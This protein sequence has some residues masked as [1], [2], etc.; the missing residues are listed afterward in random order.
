MLF[1][2]KTND[3]HRI[4][5]TSTRKK[6]ERAAFGNRKERGVEEERGGRGRRRRRRRRAERRRR[7]RIVKRLCCARLFPHSAS[8]FLSFLPFFF[9]SKTLSAIAAM[10]LLSSA[11]Y[12]EAGLSGLLRAQAGTGSCR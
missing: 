12:K 4:V 1:L 6:S 3:S 2:E 5:K 8:L 7:R 11:L 9:F 10:S